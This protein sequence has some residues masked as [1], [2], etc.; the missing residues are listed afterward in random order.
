[1]KQDSQI[2]I[3]Q[4]EIESKKKLYTECLTLSQARNLFLRYLHEHCIYSLHYSVVQHIISLFSTG[5]LQSLKIME[6]DPESLVI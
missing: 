1:M 4:I 2:V 3:F 5:R 6:I